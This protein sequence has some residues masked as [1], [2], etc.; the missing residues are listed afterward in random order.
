MT[1][2]GFATLDLHVQ[3]DARVDSSVLNCMYLRTLEKVVRN[4][5]CVACSGVIVRIYI[6]FFALLSLKLFL[7]AFV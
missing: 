4:K 3:I 5:N 1:V 2:L 6:I 7:Y